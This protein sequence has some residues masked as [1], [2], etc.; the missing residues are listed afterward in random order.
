MM[1]IPEHIISRKLTSRRDIRLGNNQVFGFSYQRKQFFAKIYKERGGFQRETFALENFGKS[2]IPVPKI[3]FK[4]TSHGGTENCLV[5]TERIKGTTLDKV[6]RS[7]NKYCYQ[8]GR[9]L[10]KIHAIKIPAMVRPLVIPVEEIAKGIRLFA[11][12]EKIAHPLL[13]FLETTLEEL[14][15]SSDIVMSH[16][17]YIG[18]HIFVFRGT[19]SGI[20]DWECIR[21]ARP[22]IDLGHCSAFL[23]IFGGPE[24]MQ[25]FIRGY[26]LTFDENINNRLKLYY[27]IIFARYWKRLNREQEYQRAICSIRSQPD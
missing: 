24:D 9:L 4:S 6:E 5:I 7:R 13:R 8:V 19:V 23:E 16:G 10:A 12:Q 3:V 11:D 18:R 21:A 1:T 14:N 17:D 15:L 26:G 22:E 2:D 27:K 20:V 25:S